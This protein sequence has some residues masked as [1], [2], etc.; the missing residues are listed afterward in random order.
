MESSQYVFE[1]LLYNHLLVINMSSVFRIVL[2]LKINGLRTGGEEWKRSK[3]QLIRKDVL[4]DPNSFPTESTRRGMTR[5]RENGYKNRIAS[6]GVVS[7]SVLYTRDGRHDSR[8][9]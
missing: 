6:I 3:I 2:L 7:P 1:R 9:P 5:W 8:G 4:I